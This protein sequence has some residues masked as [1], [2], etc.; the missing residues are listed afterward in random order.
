MLHIAWDVIP[1][2]RSKVFCFNLSPLLLPI[3]IFVTGKKGSYQNE[4][5]YEKFA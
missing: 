1:V 4:A 5:P 3:T 2:L